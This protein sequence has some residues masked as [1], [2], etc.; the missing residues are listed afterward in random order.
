LMVRK[1]RGIPRARGRHLE[2]DYQRGG[3]I[4][5]LA[6]QNSRL[7]T[8]HQFFSKGG[9]N[10]R[11][12]GPS[13]GGKGKPGHTGVGA[14]DH[15]GGTLECRLMGFIRSTGRGGPEI[16]IRVA[17][18]RFHTLEVHTPTWLS[19]GPGPRVSSLRRKRTKGSLLLRSG[20]LCRG[21]FRTRVGLGFHGIRP[22]LFRK[23][24]WGVEGR[25]L[26]ETVKVPTAA[27]LSGTVRAVRKKID[28]NVGR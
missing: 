8:S 4:N 9:G 26:G 10:W 23:R 7:Q 3:L 11:G 1:G 2:D 27:L 13:G 18:S 16:L 22:Y 14:E 6:A 25:G 15:R 17:C 28:E 21:G 20:L 24:A 12:G 5:R 19:A